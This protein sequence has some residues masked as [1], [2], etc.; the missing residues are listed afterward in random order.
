MKSNLDKI[1]SKEEE[2][3]AKVSFINAEKTME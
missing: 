2:M 3:I 1:K